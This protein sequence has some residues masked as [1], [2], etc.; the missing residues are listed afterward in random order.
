MQNL[1]KNPIIYDFKPILAYFLPFCRFEVG[2]Y[3]F[4][5][6]YDKM[7]VNH[8]NIKRKTANNH[9][10]GAKYGSKRH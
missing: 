8:E 7:R 3:D 1:L 5:N 2:L 4:T 6:Y 9:Q 10:R